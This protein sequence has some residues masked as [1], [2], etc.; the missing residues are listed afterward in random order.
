MSNGQLSADNTAVLIMH[1]LF[2]KQEI[3]KASEGCLCTRPNKL[4]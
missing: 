4:K 3:E 1:R 2:A